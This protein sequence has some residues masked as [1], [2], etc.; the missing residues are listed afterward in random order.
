M[1]PARHPARLVHPAWP[2]GRWAAL[3]V[4]VAVLSA[5]GGSDGPST[6]AIKV[7]GD[8]LNDSGTFGAKAT[9]QSSPA[10]ATRI[11]TDHVADA[12][13]AP[14]L[15]ARYAPVAAAGSVA[16]NPAAVTCTS[17]AVAGATINPPGTDRDAT[18]YS[19]VQQLKDLAQQPY[20]SDELL[21]VGGGGN[22]AA[23]VLGA[24][25]G[26]TTPQGYAAYAGLLAERLSAAQLAA[27]SP[28]DPT[29][30]VAA[31][32]Q[33]MASLADLMAD[34]LEAEALARGARRVAVMNMPDVVLTPR[35]RDVLAGVTATAGA[36]AAA[37]VAAIGTGWVQ[38]YNA[39]LAQRLQGRPEVL[40]VDV[41]AL[42]G[43]WTAN[44][45][46][47][48]FS[49]VTSPACPPTGLSGGFPTYSLATCTETVLSATPNA[50]GASW[51]QG[52][53]YSDNFHGTPKTNR[54]LADEFIA[55]IRAKGWD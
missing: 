43:R 51:W 53:L 34:T 19:V 12:V 48:G 14:A 1:H 24:Y 20:R 35:F 18:G 17:Y 15:C 40:V 6:S 36:A 32:G 37:Q 31:G 22:D 16:L 46:A 21:L 54:L 30:L 4:A 50:A 33:Y 42:L 26:A 39:R 52:Y 3:A 47:A 11:W 45:G 9:V 38:A 10:S 49:N 7:V 23:A 29:T 41:A 25:L 27:L 2:R 5:C 55:A 44:P 28:A 8:S 13:G